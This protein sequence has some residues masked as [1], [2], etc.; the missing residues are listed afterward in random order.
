MKRVKL[1]DLL[2]ILVVVG[3]GVYILH[4]Q[5]RMARLEK[6]AMGGDGLDA[7]KLLPM[8]ATD[9]TGAAFTVP[10]GTP[11]LVFYMS[12]HCGSCGKNMPAWSEAAHRIGDGNALFLIAEPA[13]MKAIDPYLDR[14]AAKSVPV[15]LA[16][17]GVIHE[18]LM[19]EVPRTLLIDDR[20][21]VQKVWRGVVTAPAILQAWTV[22]TK[23][24]DPR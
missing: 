14:F 15:A 17:R 5:H 20:G 7:A 10:A 2:S 4:M 1:I 12:P 9:R 11:R 6:V 23:S 3:L 18:H 16:D 19:N 24:E 21:R 22:L 8:P 13:G